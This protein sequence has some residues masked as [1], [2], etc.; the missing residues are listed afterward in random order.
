MSGGEGIGLLTAE[1][2]AGALVDEL[3]PACERVEIAG[4]IRRRTPVVGDIELVLVPRLEMRPVEGQVSMFADAERPWP[5][6]LD[7]LAQLEAEGRVQAIKP[8]TSEVVPWSLRPDGRYW[9]LLL[10]RAGVRAD[11]F[12][13]SPDR[14]GVIFT[15][16]T[17]SWRFSKALVERWT[18]I[19]K[20][21]SEEGLLTWP[22]GRV[23]PT[24]EEE[25]VFRA[26]RL[27]WV[28]PEERVD[29]DAVRKAAR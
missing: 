29:G 6:P 17:G 11:L 25:D 23:E 20:G 8:G 5:L 21:H 9:R 19:S 12:V 22:D 10:P 24:P 4:S 14:W 26:C 13:T 28:P 15:I 27:A 18:E 1:R 7:V 16:R 3:A 2:V